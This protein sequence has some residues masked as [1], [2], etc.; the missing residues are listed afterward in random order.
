M[1]HTKSQNNYNSDGTGSYPVT[2]LGDAWQIMIKHVLVSCY[3]V[4]I[5][6]KMYTF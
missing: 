1:N 6:F 5:R 3:Y 4:N 2:P